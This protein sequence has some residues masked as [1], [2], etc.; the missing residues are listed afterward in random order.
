VGLV[1]L[2]VLAFRWN[3]A[4]GQSLGHVWKPVLVAVHRGRRLKWSGHSIALT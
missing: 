4:Q 1:V 3:L 2:A